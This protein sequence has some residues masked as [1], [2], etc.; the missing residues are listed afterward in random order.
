M[1]KS[2]TMTTPWISGDL[3]S[4]DKIIHCTSI[5]TW[6]WIPSTCIKLLAWFHVALTP[7]V[8]EV[9]TGRCWGVM[10][11]R[12]APYLQRDPILREQRKVIEKN[13]RCPLLVSI[14]AGLYTTYTYHILCLCLC[15]YVFLC[16]S[17]S[18]F[19][20]T[21]THADKKRNYNGIMNQ[22]VLPSN[23]S[24]SVIMHNVI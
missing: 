24:T 11:S 4:M 23:E 6:V 3:Y 16:L 7:A 5:R 12:L 14:C 13:T 9:E 19:S 15:I 17:V 18:F 21:H 20:F 8:Y 22:A 10:A 2:S 1:V